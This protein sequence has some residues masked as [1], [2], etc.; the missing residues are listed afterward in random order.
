MSNREEIIALVL[1]YEGL[2][3]AR[4]AAYLQNSFGGNWDECEACDNA[5]EAFIREYPSI[6]DYDDLGNYVGE[7]PNENGWTP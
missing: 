3:D 7:M 1:K 2:L 5:L 4:D 6:M